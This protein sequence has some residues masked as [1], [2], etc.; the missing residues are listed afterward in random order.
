MKFPL[1]FHKE[2]FIKKHRF[3]LFFSDG[4][5]FLPWTARPYGSRGSFT[6]M[7]GISLDKKLAGSKLRNIRFPAYFESPENDTIYLWEKHNTALTQVGFELE[8]SAN[9]AD[10]LP[11]ELSSRLRRAQVDIILTMATVFQLYFRVISGKYDTIYSYGRRAFNNFA[12][13]IVQLPKR[14]P[15]I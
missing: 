14:L 5:R 9:R 11:T 15:L 1:N 4:F 10:A 3:F 2:I 12:S 6:Q 8:Y 13:W 7:N